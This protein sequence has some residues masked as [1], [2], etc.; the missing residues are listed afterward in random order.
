VRF[1]IEGLPSLQT[2]LDKEAV[3]SGIAASRKASWILL[4]IVV[5][6]LATSAA[7]AP[8]TG[9]GRRDSL[10][11]TLDALLEVPALRSATVGVEVR[12]LP[13]GEVLYSRNGEKSLRPASIQKLLSTALA[14]DVL[15]SER[16]FLTTVE[17]ASPID[18]GGLI[19]GDVYFVGR[20]DPS[21][22]GR[23]SAEDALA[24]VD[25]L[26]DEIRAAGVRRI[27]GRVL[28]HGALFP[29]ERR[30]SD[31]GW[32]DLVWW[33]GAEVSALFVADGCVRLRASAGAREGDPVTLLAD[34][35]SSYYRVVSSAVTAS[36]GGKAELTLERP[37]GQ[38]G[39]WLSGT[40]AVGE[41][42]WEGWVALENPALFA[43]TLLAERLTA[44]GIPVTA[45]SATDSGPLPEGLRVLASRQSPTVAEIVRMVNKESHNLGA[46]VLLRHGGIAAAGQGTLAGGR[47][48]TLALLARLGVPAETFVIE[49]GSGLSRSDLVTAK[50]MAAL[51]VAMDD[52]KAAA[53]FR[54]SLPVAGV[55]GTLAHRMKSSAAVGRVLAKTGT[56]RATSSLAG[57]VTT[58]SGNRMAFAFIVNNAPSARQA[59][60]ALDALA[61]ALASR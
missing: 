59:G 6:G 4:G 33:Y 30:G 44:A 23:Y 54:A 61:V 36:A 28:G 51:L 22:G 47:D 35:P 43:A 56:L 11:P 5:A 21:L 31:W 48:G 34:P 60:A 55:D 17:T 2:P 42:P 9:T 20:G 40:M 3:V 19:S 18:S 12:R 24:S 52:H 10:E 57:Y 45:G 38:N 37:S 13:G 26:V 46:E 49:D 29:G 32:E 58:R 39:I 15:G 7:G 8:P 16:R 14:L 1:G 50:G 27:E 25:R 41:A 53:D